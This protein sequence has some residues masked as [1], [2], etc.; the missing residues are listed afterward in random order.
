MEFAAF[1]FICV[2]WGSTFIATER[3]SHAL[4]PVGIGI[5]RLLGGTAVLTVLWLARH[6]GYRIP[7]RDWPALF[8]YTLTVVTAYVV[9]PYVLEQGF[10]HSFF[11][12][13]VALIPLMTIA[14]SVPLLNVRPTPRELF[15][16]VGGFA[17]IILLLSDG[18]NRGMSPGLVAL[19]LMIP[20]CSAIGNPLVK[21][22]LSHVP[23]LPITAAS[24]GWAGLMLV[25]L[26][27]FPQS[28]ASAGLAGPPVPHDLPVVIWAMVFLTIVGT[29]LSTL[30]FIWL[31]MRRGPLFPSM[32][33]YIV[34][35]IGLLWGRYDHEAITSR[36]LVAMA[37]VLLMVG[38][39]QL[40][41]GRKA[42]ITR[43]VVPVRQPV[44]VA[45]EAA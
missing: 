22:S 40:R 15:G 19:A 20:L 7:R 14:T 2:V 44:R 12:A 30:A 38:V 11:S 3:A 24:L 34:P 16:V 31:V 32:T 4:G 36:Q 5:G 29:A 17:C 26:E 9:Q 41:R 43:V 42:S 6:R 21:R 35:I 28:L 33:T 8:V 10:G 37:G 23:S 27:C 1:A 39:V 13:M 45:R 25:P 18:F